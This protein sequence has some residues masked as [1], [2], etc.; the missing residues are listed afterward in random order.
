MS[1]SSHT[2]VCSR[3]Q[4]KDFE[5]EF[6]GS[7]GI[8]R[9]RILDKYQHA[10]GMLNAPPFEER[11]SPYKD[12]WGL[13]E[14]RNALVHYKPTWDLE[15]QRQVELAEVLKRD[16][17]ALSPFPD[18]GADFVAMKCMSAGCAGWVISTVVTLIEEFDARAKLDPKRIEAFRKLAA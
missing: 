2:E 5:T 11:T 15:R 1:S 7:R 18:A 4:L 9:K 12:A 14:L 13:I 10:L 6:W 17:F 3:A 8:E 16:R